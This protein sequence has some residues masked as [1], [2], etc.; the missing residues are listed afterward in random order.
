MRDADFAP[1]GTALALLQAMSRDLSFVERTLLPLLQH[2]FL[3][4]SSFVSMGSF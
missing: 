3:S 4:P 2:G 1:G